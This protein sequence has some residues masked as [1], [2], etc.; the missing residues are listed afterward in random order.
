MAIS[1]SNLSKCHAETN[2]VPGDSYVGLSGLLGMTSLVVQCKQNDKLKFAQQR[3][4]ASFA[5]PVLRLFQFESA[6]VELIV[7]ALLSN[8]ILMSAALDD[9]AVVQNHDTIG[10][11][12]G[13]KP[14]GD[15]KHRAAMH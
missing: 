5:S 12:D 2:I 6:G 3:G 14:M 9:M 4:D 8:Q 13:R 10:I 15:D 11:H 7:G 1:C